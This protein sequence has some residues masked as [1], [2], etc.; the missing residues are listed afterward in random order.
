[1]DVIMPQ[2][3]ETVL[4]GSVANWYKKVGDTVTADEPLFDVETDKVTTEIPAPASGVLSQILV[5]VGVSVKVG[6][7]LAVIETA[8]VGAAKAVSAPAAVTPASTVAAKA[9]AASLVAGR[10]RPLPRSGPGG[11]RLS[12]V[13]RRLLGEHGL[14]ADEIKGT[15]RDGRITREDVLAY[16]NRVGAAP[17]KGAPIMVPA[18]HA[19]PVAPAAPLLRSADTEP[20]PGPTVVAGPDDLVVP[21]SKIR[22]LTAAHMVRS[23]AVSPHTL[24]AVEVDFHNVEK[25]RKAIG[26]EWKAR[27]GFS[28][29]YLPFVARAVCDAITKFPYVNASFANDEL[30]VHKK[31]HLGIAVDL[32]F[33]ALLATVVRDAH[34][35]NL[36]GLALEI[37]RLVDAARRGALKPDELSGGTYTISNSGTF[38]TLFSAPIINQPQAAILSTDG[39]RKKPVVLEGPEGDAIV[40]RPIGVLAQSFDHRAFDGAYSAA[41]LRCLK[42]LLENRDWV[43]ECS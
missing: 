8:N 4:E 21:L 28:L 36:R 10:G 41:F 5:D 7:R 15:G 22:R 38:G 16:L 19:S 18:V 20:T 23:K 12:P 43:A 37:H 11:P 33:E 30:I 14:R 35:R 34:H 42:E 32:N 6:T 3:G 24:Q 29:T 31:V 25:A 1:M 17:A 40:I 39:V 2:L 13:V 9:G 26:A 27:E